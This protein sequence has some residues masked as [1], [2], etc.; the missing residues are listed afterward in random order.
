M[1]HLLPTLSLL[2]GGGRAVI[3][4]IHAAESAA[5]LPS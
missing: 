4:V 1:S 2:A 3:A 5:S